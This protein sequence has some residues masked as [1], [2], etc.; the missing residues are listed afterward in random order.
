MP[1]NAL[2]HFPLVFM[3]V[4]LGTMDLMVQTDSSACIHDLHGE[5]STPSEVKT[6]IRDIKQKVAM[7]NSCKFFKDPRMCINRAHILDTSARKC[8][9]C[10]SLYCALKKKKKLQLEIKWVWKRRGGLE[11]FFYNKI[12]LFVRMKKY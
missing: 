3:E 7:F 5:P 2:R 10:S 9:N 6:I 8:H 12:M 1:R 11:F 4:P